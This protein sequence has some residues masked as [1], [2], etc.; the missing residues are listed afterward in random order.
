MHVP[1]EA[2]IT[3]PSRSRASIALKVKEVDRG[4]LYLWPLQGHKHWPKF[5][6]TCTYGQSAS[7][8]LGPPN[9]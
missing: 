9:V 3:G 5:D 6:L 4:H 2:K 8:L 7:P 1:T